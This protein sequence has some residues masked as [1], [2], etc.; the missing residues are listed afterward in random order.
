[1]PLDSATA[2]FI[3][4][5][6]RS[7]AKHIHEMT[8][9]ESRSL[10]PL[11]RKIMGEG[12]EV[13]SVAADQVTYSGG[14]FDIRVI[15]PKA[16]PKGVIVYYHGGGWVIGHVDD[17]EP[18]G[19]KLAHR[20]ECTV[21]MVN[22]RLAPE[23]RF[24]TAV[25]DAYAALEWAQRNV[26][27]LAGRQVPMIVAGDS[28]GANLAAVV[29]RRA[30]DRHG[31][32][33]AL[34]VLVYPVTDA[35]MSM[36]SYFHPDN[37][38]MLTRE[39]M[40]YFWDHYVPHL[41]DRRRPDASPLREPNLAG[42]PPAVLFTAE[43]DPLRDEGE[44]YAVRLL[45]AGVSVQFCRFLGQIH[46]FLAMVNVLPASDR[47]IDQIARAIDAQLALLAS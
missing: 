44:A 28:A 45:E 3:A 24:P 1:M 23:F 47:A 17:F 31:P 30:R 36:P 21:V 41:P 42:L 43:Y 25:D 32:F 13:A 19:R 40:V 26:E 18:L 46:G 38:H 22:Y 34:Q 33:I 35:D 14:T 37:Q 39:S 9:E 2:A 10:G 11:M 15:V 29:S 20:C 27:R 6:Q 7:G 12:P 8:L 5:S 16:T 4:Q